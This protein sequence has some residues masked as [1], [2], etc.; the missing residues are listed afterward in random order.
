MAETS[1]HTSMPNSM[2]N[3]TLN[4]LCISVSEQPPNSP[5]PDLLIVDD[6]PDNIRFLSKF[7]MAQGYEVRKATSGA[8]ALRAIAALMPDLILLDVNMGEMSGYELCTRLKTDPATQHIPIIFLS[9][10]SDTLDKVQAFKVGGSDYITKP[11]QLEEVLVRIQTQLTLRSLQES[12][13]IQNQKLRQTLEDLKRAQASLIQQEKMSTLKKVVAGVAHEVNNPLSFIAGNVEPARQ[14]VQTLVE[15]SHLYQQHYPDPPAAIRDFQTEVDLDFVAED[16]NKI[17]RSMKTGA[18]RIK[19]VVS[20]L[21]SFTHLDEAGLK[22]I[23]LQDTVETVLTL[24]R[25]RLENRSTGTTI[26]VRKHYQSIPPVNCYAEQISQA[27]FNLLVNAVDAVEAKLD[28]LEKNPSEVPYTPEIVITI[29]QGSERCILLQIQDN[30][31]GLSQEKQSRLFEPFFSTKPA[32]K[33]LG[34]GLVTARRI[35]EEQHY[36]QLT[37]AFEDHCTT[38]SI[39]IPISDLALSPVSRP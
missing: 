26:Q 19:T 34:L 11:F 16:L 10:G 29:R 20:A 39:S 23:S 12:Q 15:L 13:K 28:H 25:Y 4:P 3:A 38:F 8:M 6:I 7:L 9:A 32:G 18:A 35:I 31:I 36:G 21:R 27:I 22:R 2:P 33:G 24:L 1:Q 14:Y 37:Y 30:G 5:R 17:L